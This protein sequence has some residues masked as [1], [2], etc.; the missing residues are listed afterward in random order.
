M[1]GGLEE[2]PFSEPRPFPLSGR[3]LREGQVGGCLRGRQAGIGG[4]PKNGDRIICPPQQANKFGPVFL[5]ELM[6]ST[7]VGAV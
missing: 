1:R 2:E 3:P 5:A 4:R 7:E 6:Y